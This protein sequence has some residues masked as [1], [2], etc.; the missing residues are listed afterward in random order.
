MGLYLLTEDAN[1]IKQFFF[2]CW[3]SLTLQRKM[4]ENLAIARKQE[5][6]VSL[7]SFLISRLFFFDMP[8]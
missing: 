2:F 8:S 6:A 1:N 3:Q 7:F 4:A 5:M